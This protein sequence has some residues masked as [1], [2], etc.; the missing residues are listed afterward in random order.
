MIQSLGLFLRSM[1]RYI[2]WLSVDISPTANLNDSITGIL[3]SAT[4][5]NK[6]VVPDISI[7]SSVKIRNENTYISSSYISA[8]RVNLHPGSA[9][10]L[11]GSF[12]INM[13]SN[14]VPVTNLSKI[15]IKLVGNKGNSFRL[16]YTG[17]VNNFSNVRY[18]GGD[19]NVKIIDNINQPLNNGENYFWV[20]TDMVG[21]NVSGDSILLQ[22]DSF[23][24]NNLKVNTTYLVSQNSLSYSNVIGGAYCTPEY[25]AR[26][27]ILD[28]VRINNQKGATE[29]VGLYQ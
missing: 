23:V 28:S 13:S 16:F 3:D 20:T 6:T 2:S 1:I 9:Q 21:S 25:E 17:G 14:G 26:G 18:V 12:K 15:Y 10:N 29:V 7:P 11:I 27:N 22:L 4:I 5:T 19:T 24:L 8:T